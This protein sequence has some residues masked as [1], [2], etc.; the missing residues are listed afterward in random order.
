MNS[1]WVGDW[2]PR[3]FLQQDPLSFHSF[4]I[5][6]GNVPQ[7]SRRIYHHIQGRWSSD[8]FLRYIRSQVK[9]FSKGVNELIISLDIYTFFTIPD[10]RIEY[11]DKDSQIPNNNNSLTSSYNS[12]LTM[13]AVTCHHVFEWHK[14]EDCQMV[15]CIHKLAWRGEFLSENSP[16]SPHWG[17]V[18]RKI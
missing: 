2:P 13:S 9:E 8:A 7:E 16:N 3:Y 6:P 15:D 17:V 18:K 10:S 4:W 12:H 14:M 11:N 1:W 5:D